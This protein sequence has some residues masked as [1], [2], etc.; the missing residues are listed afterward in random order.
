MI[1]FL[2]YDD[3][4]KQKKSLNNSD[5]SIDSYLSE[6][7]SKK[8]NITINVPFDDIPLFEFKKIYQKFQIDLNE[9]KINL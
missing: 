7:Y 6:N 8:K 5:S 2:D 9:N 3:K 1:L 4:N